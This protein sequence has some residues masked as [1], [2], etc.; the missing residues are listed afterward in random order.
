MKVAYL[1][2][3][4]TNGEVE[5]DVLNGGKAKEMREDQIAEGPVRLAS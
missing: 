3:R 5:V 4:G 1:S 2:E